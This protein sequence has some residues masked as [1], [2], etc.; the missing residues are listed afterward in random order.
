MY[1]APE[2]IITSLKIE[3]HYSHCSEK[4]RKKIRGSEIITLSGEQIK[5]HHPIIWLDLTH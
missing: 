4:K 2:L 3:P 5:N 1:E